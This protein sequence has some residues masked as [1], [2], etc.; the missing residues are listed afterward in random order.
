MVNKRYLFSWVQLSDTHFGHGDVAQGLDRQLVLRELHRDIENFKK[1]KLP[2]PDAFFITGD[3]A[4]SGSIL[5]ESE[6]KDAYEWISGLAEAVN[7]EAEQIFVVPG[8]HDVQRDVEQRNRKAA[9]LLESLRSGVEKIDN[10]LSRP[11]DKFLLTSR[12]G[13]YLEFAKNFT[14]GADELYWMRRV[15]VNSN[16]IIRV[17]GLNTAVLCA[18]DHDKARIELG[19]T[20]LL[21]AF[22]SEDIDDNEVVIVLTH[23]PFDWLRDYKSASELTA[24]YAHMHLCGHIHE[25]HNEHYRSGGGSD[26][27]RIVSGA[28]HDALSSDAA[29]FGYSF[30]ALVKEDGKI[31]VRIWPRLWSQKNCDFRP[32]VENIPV[33]GEFAQHP[34][35]ISLVPKKDR[36]IA[37][38]D[39]PPFQKEDFEYY[40]PSHP[41]LEV[42]LAPVPCTI[43]QI[44]HDDA[45]SSVVDHIFDYYEVRQQAELLAHEDAWEQAAEL[46][47]KSKTAKEQSSAVRRTKRLDLYHKVLQQVQ[48]PALSN[49]TW[50]LVTGDTGTGKT[51]IVRQLARAFPADFVDL[52]DYSP[53]KPLDAITQHTEPND[54]DLDEDSGLRAPRILILDALDKMVPGATY[55]VMVNN[56]REI[57]AFAMGYHIVVITARPAFFRTHREEQLPGSKHVKL[58]PLENAQ[59]LTLAGNAGVGPEFISALD[60][61]ESVRDL[62]T[63]PLLLQIMIGMLRDGHDIT[64]LEDDEDL[65]AYVVDSW[66]SRDIADAVLPSDIRLKCMQCL[67]LHSLST[68]G[69]SFSYSSIDDLIKRV[70][71]PL[72]QEQVES[73]NTDLRVCGFLRRLD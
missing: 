41:V 10:V 28:A 34:L 63:K 18:D 13:N 45:F 39:A 42:G 1:H 26:F 7:L 30:G 60:R 55:Q 3:I 12:L 58:L 69:G 50:L 21:H 5:A 4:F 16:L 19:K 36:K 47:K 22:L 24:K 14:F 66:L 52:R 23:H 17:I 11:D 71:S 9:R 35:R 51:T 61:S 49:T 8:N 65:F 33:L 72:S 25:A 6:Y 56:L 40:L 20:Q 68:G 31:A 46:L 54:V 38:S 53:S 57:R 48:M 15:S 44:H 64:G 70:L 37:L 43:E 27:V 32:D 2:R 59:V 29:R 62:S 67:A 73:F